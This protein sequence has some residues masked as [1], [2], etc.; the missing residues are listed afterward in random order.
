VNRLLFLLLLLLASAALAAGPDTIRLIGPP[1]PKIV[2]IGPPTPRIIVT[3]SNPPAITVNSPVASMVAIVTPG[4]QGP[5]GAT[6][7]GEGGGG[8]W[9][10]IIGTLSDQ[11]DLQTALA[12]KAF[13]GH[14][15]VPVTYNPATFTVTTGTLESG[16][17]ASLIAIDGDIARINEAT[18]VPGYNIELG[19]SGVNIFNK[20]LL[21]EQY[22][23][24][25]V[26]DVQ[27]AFYN[28]DTTAWDLLETINSQT[29]I[30]AKTYD[31][32]NPAPYIFAGQVKVR[33]YHASSGNPAHYF[34]LD[35]AVLKDD[36]STGAAD[37]GALTSLTD[38]DHPQYALRRQQATFGNL[39][40]QGKI[41]GPAGVVTMGSVVNLNGNSIY[42]GAFDGTSVR[43]S[44]LLANTLNTYNG[45]KF[46]HVSSII[47]HAKTPIPVPCIDIMDGAPGAA[48][49]AGPAGLTG[50]ISAG[51]TTTLD[52]GQS[53]YVVFTGPSTARTAHFGIPKGAQGDPGTLTQSAVFG[54]IDEQ[55]N[56]P[57]LLQGNADNDVKAQLLYASGETSL[58]LTSGGMIFAQDKAGRISWGWNNDSREMV[59]SNYS[60]GSA[61]KSM[62]IDRFGQVKQYGGNG[63]TLIMQ[64]YTSG[65][66]KRFHPI[67]GLLAEHIEPDGK[68][69]L[70]RPNGTTPMMINYTAGRL[71]L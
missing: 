59:F 19:Y 5:A 30:A 47:N 29:V 18:G 32:L 23:G 28:W 7:A 14:V 34:R 27:I 8:T 15:H 2:V 62:T 61:R 55:S 35:Y 68:R 64:G 50:S 10:S 33:F 21:H 25:P 63:T 17:L 20:L 51:T 24:S 12:A 4:A 69:T 53:A 16:S 52:P 3:G 54:A 22:V 6:V 46:A 70:Y 37:H 11:A 9:G 36:Y 39:S 38:D 13:T 66:V 44:G 1:A 48:G 56:L 57:L 45:A 31:I 60:Y 42:G 71:V 41:Y 67:S 40:A 58:W 26:H 49:A 65:R 43:G